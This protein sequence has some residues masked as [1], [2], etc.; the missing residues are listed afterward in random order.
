LKVETR[1][2]LRF[3]DQIFFSGTKMLKSSQEKELRRIIEDEFDIEIRMRQRLLKQLEEEVERT[4]R[5]IEAIETADKLQ[6]CQPIPHK[7]LALATQAPS[8]DDSTAM[9]YDEFGSRRGRPRKKLT[10]K[11]IRGA[12]AQR[13]DG[14]FVKLFCPACHR[15][16]FANRVGFMNHCRHLHSIA[17]STTEEWLNRCGIPV[18]ESQVPLDDPSRAEPSGA[19]FDASLYDNV[20]KLDGTTSETKDDIPKEGHSLRARFEGRFSRKET[21]PLL[22]AAPVPIHE[23]ILAAENAIAVPP[24]V[25]AG[26]ANKPDSQFY[27]KR[28]VVI[29]NVSMFMPLEKRGLDES[30]THKWMVYVRSPKCYDTKQETLRSFIRSVKFTLHPT[31]KP[32]DVV[33][34]TKPPFQV[35][36]RGWGEFPV[37]AEISFKD[38]DLNKPI[39]L[40]HNLSLDKTNCGRQIAAPES[41][42]EIELDRETFF[43]SNDDF[44]ESDEEPSKIG[45]TD[46]EGDLTLPTTPPKA[47]SLVSDSESIIANAGFQT[48]AS[49][50]LMKKEE[51]IE[52][53]RKANSPRYCRYC[54][55][56]YD[57]LR[58]DTTLDP[59]KGNRKM[60]FKPSG[61]IVINHDPSRCQFRPMKKGKIKLTMCTV[62]N[63]LPL[64]QEVKNMPAKT[65]TNEDHMDIVQNESVAEALNDLP[66]MISHCFN[67]KDDGVSDKGELIERFVSSPFMKGPIQ[68]VKQLQYGT[69]ESVIK[70]LQD[71]STPV[72]D[73][74]ESIQTSSL[75]YL[76]MRSFLKKLMDGATHVYRQE[77]IVEEEDTKS[78]LET[79]DSALNSEFIDS[80]KDDRFKGHPE[81]ILCPFHLFRKIYEKRDEYDFLLNTWMEGLKDTPEALELLGLPLTVEQPKTQQEQSGS[82]APSEVSIVSGH[83]MEVDDDM[84]EDEDLVGK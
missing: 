62:T 14:T 4:E 35:V 25:E 15:S 2:K 56:R 77:T 30:C 13:K 42:Y 16:D 58:Y 7:I 20:A 33:L 41:V 9:D 3:S 59:Y 45:K 54:G 57:I 46:V 40:V 81:K 67:S 47:T 63:V 23:K 27:A 65:L 36:R 79:S 80:K 11:P 76:L 60:L 52:K 74:E 32:N 51:K 21:S 39:E 43:V 37:K 83:A 1:G 66:F 22:G 19:R 53:E 55:T 31:Y 5:L 75:L 50:A 69:W 12:F 28:K 29:G 49:L 48:L 61:N 24:V 71:S 78:F 72:S 6:H 70:S 34:I 8:I 38:E 44:S 84:D 17:F 26:K 68:A 18:A 64:L 82:G 10:T 73:K